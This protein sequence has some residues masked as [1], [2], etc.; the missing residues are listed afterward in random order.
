M[1]KASGTQN[2]SAYARCCILECQLAFLHTEALV[3]S[4]SGISEKPRKEC[5]VCLICSWVS[6]LSFLDP[7][8]AICPTYG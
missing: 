7:T 5:A 3:S 4:Y 8:A 6:N 2:K 1:C